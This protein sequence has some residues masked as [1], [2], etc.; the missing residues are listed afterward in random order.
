MIRR[1]AK[2]AG[3][4]LLTVLLANPYSVNFFRKQAYDWVNH[5]ASV[6]DKEAIGEIL[7][8][9]E[10]VPY[11]ALDSVY[12]IATEAHLPKYK[13][14]LAGTTYYR[15]SGSALYQKV[16]GDFR[17]LDFIAKDAGYWQWLYGLNNHVYWLVDERMLVCL[18]DLQKELRRK[19]YRP[20]AFWIRYAHR[21]PRLNREVNGVRNSRH[22][23]GQAIDLVIE[24]IDQDGQYTAADKAIVVDILDKR[25][26]KDQGGIGRYPGTRTV[27]FDTRGY[28]ARWDQH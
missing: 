12:L 17:I 14:L 6:L 28:R 16:V 2:I 10:R 11:S 8:G 18:L 22:I 7:D 19:G 24:D 26:I 13:K 25:V 23:L 5:N 27:H 20:D 4:L 9:F 21:P 3:G 15:V 1:L